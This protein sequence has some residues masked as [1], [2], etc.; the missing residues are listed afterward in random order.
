M[1]SNL[2]LVAAIV[3]FV[4]AAIGEALG[5]IVLVPAGLALLAAAL[6]SVDGK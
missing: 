1:V 5:G 4:L 2:L 6:I 3:L